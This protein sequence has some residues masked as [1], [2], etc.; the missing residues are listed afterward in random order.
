MKKC[1]FPMFCLLAITL[2]AACS[3]KAL[4]RKAGVGREF[5]GMNETTLKKIAK[6]TGIPESSIV[7]PDLTGFREIL[8]QVKKNEYAFPFLYFLNENKQPY[9]LPDTLSK[10]Q[11]LGL[12][13]KFL[14]NSQEGQVSG[15]PKQGRFYLARDSSLAEFASGKRYLVLGYVYQMGKVHKDFY[16]SVQK[17]AA[18]P[19]KNLQLFLVFADGKKLQK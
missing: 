17:L 12:V 6:E 3:E 11:C 5:P 15:E 2:F 1:Y 10:N 18:Q 16:R 7:L 4:L 19:E 13:E 14:V 9:K 8:T